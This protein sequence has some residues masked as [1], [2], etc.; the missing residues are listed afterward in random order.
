MCPHALLSQAQSHIT[1]ACDNNHDVTVQLC[2][3]V[4]SGCVRDVFEMHSK[5]KQTAWILAVRLHS[6]ISQRDTPPRMRARHVRDA[7]EMRTDVTL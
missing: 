1:I 4:T 5:H 7:S 2:Y 6:A 3:K